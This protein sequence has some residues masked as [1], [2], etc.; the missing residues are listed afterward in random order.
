[1]HIL[2]IFCNISSD[3]IMSYSV[4]DGDSRG[5][6]MAFRDFSYDGLFVNGALVGGLGQLTDGE[7]GHENFRVDARGQNRGK[8]K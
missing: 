2:I 1:M 5:G 6:D 7:L 3:G 8:L 4:V